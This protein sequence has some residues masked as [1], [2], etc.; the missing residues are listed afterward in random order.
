MHCLQWLDDAAS[1]LNIKATSSNS[2]A[3]VEDALGRHLADGSSLLELGSG[4]GH[5]IAWISK[6]YRLTASD[7]CETSIAGLRM[8]FPSLPVLHLD[9]TTIQC[10][11]PF[12]AIFSNKLMQHLSADEFRSSLERQRQVVKPGGIVAHTFWFNRAGNLADEDACP[13]RVITRHFEIIEVM[14]YDAFLEHDS[15]MIIARNSRD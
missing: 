10:L 5:D 13:A 6:H 15:L 7:Q 12:D 3:G 1:G 8:A 4:L 14:Y 11:K 2:A 9:A